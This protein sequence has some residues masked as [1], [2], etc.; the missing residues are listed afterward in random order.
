MSDKYSLGLD[1]GTNSI[2]WAVVDENNEVV[3]RNNFA[4]WG[5][6]MFDQSKDASKTRTHRNS[7]RRL[8]RRKQRICLLRNIFENEIQKVDKAFFRRLDDSFYLQEDKKEKNHY[9]L[10]ND[11]YTDKQFF[12]EF[13]TIYHLRKYLI[14]SNKKEDIRFI[15]L[16][17]HHIIKYRG[18]FLYPGNK[19]E[20]NDSSK[21]IDIL[22]TINL[23]LS[24]YAEQYEDDEDYFECLTI[25][26]EGFVKE[27]EVI[28]NGNLYKDE[29]KNSLLELMNVSKK[30]LAGE[31]IIPLLCGSKVN[32]SKLYFVK[33]TWY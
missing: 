33:R 7:R 21:I 14:E 6:R 16:A 10:F 20:K 27:L 22:N 23:I 5:V 3:K 8:Q 4:L 2:G 19:F 13:P 32:L 11:C 24:K 25:N 12:D 9:N 29:K 26:K 1:I 15:Y 30:S 28:L 18:N 17:C 31:L